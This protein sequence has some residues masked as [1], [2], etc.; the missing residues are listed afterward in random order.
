MTEML[1][2]NE[3]VYSHHHPSSNHPASTGFYTSMNK[4]TVLPQGFDRFFENAYCGA[5]NPAETCLQKGEGK[6]EAESQ[7]HALSSRGEQ[8]IDP[9]DEEENT[10]PG[11]SASSSSVTK[12]GSKSSNSSR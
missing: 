3:S 9:E 6:V 8:G 5:E 11:S 4:N 1:M 7:P 10:N 12:E 2:K